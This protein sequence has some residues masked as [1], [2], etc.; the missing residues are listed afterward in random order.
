MAAILTANERTK[1]Q[2]QVKIEIPGEKEGR[3]SSIHFLEED[4]FLTR[5][6]AYKKNAGDDTDTAEKS[7]LQNLQ[8]LKSGAFIRYTVTADEFS[9]P[10]IMKRPEQLAGLGTFFG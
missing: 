1:S 4:A 5:K 10:D 8:K 7:W 9:I 6:E 3:T 2:Q